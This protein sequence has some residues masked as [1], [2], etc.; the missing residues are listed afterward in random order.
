MN[1]IELAL[2]LLED[3]E[4][5]DKY[6]NLSLSSHLLDHL[7]ANERGRVTALFYTVVEHKLTYDYYVGALSKRSLDSIDP[8]TLNLLRLGTCLIL[9]MDGCKNH[10][11]TNET[12][13]LGRNKGEKGFV[14]AI[15]RAIIKARE[16]DSLPLPDKTKNYP[17]YLSV[18]YSFS[19]KTVKLLIS[20][21]GEADA[22]LILKRY[23]SASYTDL[24]VNLLKIKREDYIALLEKEGITAYPSERSS[25]SVRIP[26]SVNP[27]TFPGYNEGFFFVQDLACAISSEVLSPRPGERIIDVCACPGGKSFSAAILANGKADV[28][29]FDLH[30]SKLSL[31][32]SSAMRLG[33]SLEVAEQDATIPRVELVGSFDRVICDVPCSGLGVLGKKPDMRYKQI[34]T[35]ELPELQLNILESSAQYLKVGGTLLYS[36]C[37]LLPEEN[38]QVVKRFL[39]AH[40]EFCFEDFSS[41]D[42][43]SRDGMMTLLPHVDMTDGFFIAKLRK[44]N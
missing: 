1:T 39:G 22:E 40:P 19:L 20:L 44:V 36:T 10:T 15:L 14:N 31:I 2:K 8:Y 13:K 7:P 34:S 18:L 5:N 32:T 17:R 37:T 38:E 21:Y 3:Y 43:V 41:G 4:N 30:N 24:S 9:D 11:A 29:S 6:A 23:N 35:E 16:A 27:T 33:I 26:H 28:F 42:R 25:I 12:V